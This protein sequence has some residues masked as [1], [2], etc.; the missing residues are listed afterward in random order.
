VPVP[1]LSPFLNE[2]V[3]NAIIST[4]SEN[5]SSSRLLLFICFIL[6]SL[7]CFAEQAPPV[8]DKPHAKANIEIGADS[9][10]R[11]Y[12][13]PYIRFEFP[14]KKSTLFTEVN[15]YQRINSQ[16]KGE[17]DFWIKAGLL[18]DFTDLLSFEGSLN[19]FCR[20]IT[21]RSYRAIFDANEV[22]GRLWYRTKNM[23]LGVGG[24]VYIGGY[25]WY[26]N[27]LVFN[28]KYPNILEA[29]FKLINFS[30]VLHDLEFFIS[31]NEN[32]D[33]FVRNT[34]HYEYD[35]TTYLGMRLK[36]GGHANNI[37]RKLEYQTGVFPSYDRHKM[38]SRHA[39]DMEFFKTQNRRLQVSLISQIPILRDDTFF[40]V[41]RPDN[42]EYPLSIQYER[43]IN[44]NLFAVGYCL[45]DVAMP[46]DIDHAFT[47]NLGFGVG[48]RNQPFF[49]KLDKTIRF[50]VFGG[51]NFAHTYDLGANLGLNTVERSLN[52]GANAKSRVNAKTFDGSLTAFGEFGSEI[53]VRIF[54]SGETTRFFNEDNSAV[55]KWQ[56]GFT[57]F[58]WF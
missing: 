2:R 33:L 53:K 42:I 50:D 21:S 48:L 25:E 20:H 27:L 40:H 8:K 28:Y 3:E 31:L 58:S 9:N 34:K 11:R 32:L 15:Y 55:N 38:K 47:S 16:L 29:E 41:F 36:S 4:F 54:V 45:Y 5:M 52:F 51:P 30:K 19:H 24:G 23:R 35:N 46:V 13:R 43:K 7:T 57:L 1:Y 10:Q 44:P 6:T 39:I 18:Y 56:F 26:D 14:I 49:E 12:F 17:V 22:L 37:I